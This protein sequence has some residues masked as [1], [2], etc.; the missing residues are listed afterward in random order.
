MTT[1]TEDSGEVNVQYREVPVGASP[2]F[3]WFKIVG[4]LLLLF[5]SMRLCSWLFA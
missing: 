3:Q 4:F 1:R 5:G 2:L